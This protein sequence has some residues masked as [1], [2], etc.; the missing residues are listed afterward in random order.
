[1]PEPIASDDAVSH[2]TISGSS[3]R[4]VHCI[5]QQLG[6]LRE[7]LDRGPKKVAARRANVEHQE[8]QLAA[9]KDQRTKLRM[10]SDEKQVQLKG[11][12]TKIDELKIKLNSISS[13]R[14]YQALLDQIAAGEMANSVLADEILEA[15]EKLDQL[16]EKV[17]AAES[18]VEKAQAEAE[19]VLREVEEE[20]PSLQADVDRLE[21]DLIESE[22]ALPRDVRDSYQRVVRAR[23]SDAL[24]AV[25]GQICTGCNQQI[26]LNAYADLMLGKPLFCPMCGCMLYVPD[27]EG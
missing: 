17:T 21:I 3:L 1:M 19:K 27:D 15:L 18:A 13:N 11:G 16:Q 20:K 22:K 4:R 10:A 8:S 14:E 9:A 26:T 7:R 24:A 25:E 2:K 23:G 12:E 5:H 6:D